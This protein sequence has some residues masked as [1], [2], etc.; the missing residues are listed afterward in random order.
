MHA[1]VFRE[2]YN[3][4]IIQIFAELPDRVRLPD[5]TT[6]TAIREMSESELQEIGLLPV[7]VTNENYDKNLYI[8]DGETFEIFNDRVEITYNLRPI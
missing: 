3:F 8:R 1:L 7:I 2:N 6:R 4:K 5:G